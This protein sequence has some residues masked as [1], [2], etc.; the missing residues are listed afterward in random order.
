MIRRK[1]TFLDRIARFTYFTTIWAANL[2]FIYFESLPES[3]SRGNQA[4]CIIMFIAYVIFPL[5]G[6]FYLYRES[7]TLN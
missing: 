6:Q 3:L 7:T 1:F 4:V 5:A 2:Q